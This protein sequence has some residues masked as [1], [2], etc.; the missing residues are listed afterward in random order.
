MKS[1]QIKMLARQILSLGFF[2]LF[3]QVTP[4]ENRAIE[5]YFESDAM[6]SKGQSELTFLEAH[7]HLRQVPE[8]KRKEFLE[9]PTRFTQF[10]SNA[11]VTHA[12]AGDALDAGL[13]NESEV[14]ARVFVAVMQELALIQQQKYVENRLL[15]DYTRQAREIFI[16]NPDRF[17]KP[18]TVTFSQI[19]LKDNATDT[20]PM[21]HRI[22]AITNE[23]Q[24][25]TSFEALVHKYSDDPSAS[26]NNGIFSNVP[27]SRLDPAFADKVR[28]LEED[29]LGIVES[30]FGTHLVVLQR[31]LPDRK[32]EFP[33]VSEQL[34]IEA[35]K[36]HEEK[37]LQNYVAQLAE[38]ELKIEEGAIKSFL[39]TYQIEWQR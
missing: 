20:M 37:V 34:K 11:L 33:D 2:L 6:A 19:L 14:A 32:A 27:L 1:P 17:T 36:R 16:A 9:S 35:R 18:A 39:D 29:V 25:G 30:R 7:A 24:N 5:I 12:M 28:N 3:P 26:E 4:A 38:P 22:D 13:L 23:Y 31:F 15:D 10:F 8:P 21:Q